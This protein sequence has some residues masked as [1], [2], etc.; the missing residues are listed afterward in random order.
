MGQLS[1]IA[2]HLLEVTYQISKVNSQQPPV[3]CIC[4]PFFPFSSLIYTPLF[5]YHSIPFYI[6]LIS[7]FFL[8]PYILPPFPPYIFLP[9]TFHNCTER[10][11]VPLLKTQRALDGDCKCNS[12]QQHWC[13]S[14]DSGLRT[15]C[16]TR[17]T[18]PTTRS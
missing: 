5:I 10:T 4:F 11:Q 8:S 1:L 9:T 17:C 3:I 12:N 13:L 7:L 6:Q 16:S 18:T 14:Q 2:C 15:T